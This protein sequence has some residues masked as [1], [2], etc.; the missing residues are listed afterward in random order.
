[1]YLLLAHQIVTKLWIVQTILCLVTSEYVYDIVVVPTT[2]YGP[3]PVYIK[4]LSLYKYNHKLQIIDV[5]YT[6]DHKGR[7]LAQGSMLRK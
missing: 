1:M 3:C 5:R 6:S 7:S 2:I 4:I